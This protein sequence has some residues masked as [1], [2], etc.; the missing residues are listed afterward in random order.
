MRACFS[1][2][3]SLPSVVEFAAKPQPFCRSRRQTTISTPINLRFAALSCLPTSAAGDQQQPGPPKPGM[4]IGGIGAVAAPG[5][6]GDTS[7]PFAD[8]VLVLSVAGASTRSIAG[9]HPGSALGCQ[10]RQMTSLSFSARRSRSVAHRRARTG[11]SCGRRTPSCRTLQ[12]QIRGIG[13]VCQD[14]SRFCIGCPRCWIIARKPLI[15]MHK[16]T[17]TDPGCHLVGATKVWGDN[18]SHRA[19]QPSPEPMAPVRRADDGL[20]TV[21]S[22]HAGSGAVCSRSVARG[23]GVI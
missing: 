1:C 3:L 20:D 11:A 13:A 4:D 19:I 14:E 18:D 23:F 10:P 6:R 21:F 15:T 16:S 5:T 8:L 22:I 7:A 12:E 17:C 9:F 2:W